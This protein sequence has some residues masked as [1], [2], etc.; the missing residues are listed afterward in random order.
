MP[1]RLKPELTFLP[2]VVVVALL[3]PA[4]VFFG[5]R[6]VLRSLTRLDK[7]VVLER[8][9]PSGETVVV[10]FR[11]KFNSECPKLAANGGVLVPARLRLHCVSWE[12]CWCLL[13]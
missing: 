12:M 4:A 3:V 7:W 10:A 13:A 11:R 2:S 8:D 5:L 9:A 1:S 6:L